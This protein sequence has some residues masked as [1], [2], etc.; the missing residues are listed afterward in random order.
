MSAIKRVEISL[1][2]L[3]PLV[4]RTNAVRS[5][6]S[7]ETP[8]VRVFDDAGVE[9]IGYSWTHGSGGSAIV[10]LLRDR[11]VPRLIGQEAD[12]IEAVWADMFRATQALSIG[13]VT[14][15]AIAAIDIAL[16]DLKG[17]KTGQSLWRMAGGAKDRLPAYTTDAGWLQFELPAVLGNV[18]RDREAGFL[19]S[20][21]K[22]GKPTLGEDLARLRAVR[23]AVGDD[24]E[25]MVDANQCFSFSEGVRRAHAFE[26]CNLGWIEEP[27]PAEDVEGHAKLRAGTSTPIANGESLYH[28]GQFRDY[29][30][31][32][33]CSITQ[34]DIARIGGITPWMKVAHMAEA[35]NIAVCPHYL[36]ELSLSLACGVPNGA[37]LEYIPQ[38]ELITDSR[39]ELKDGSAVVWDRPGTG[40]EWNEQAIAKYAVMDSI[41]VDG[42]K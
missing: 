40:I 16:W 4:Q 24:Y 22:V 39:I 20:K 6:T 21:L 32:G 30:Q 36:M 42:K 11:L 38:L 15:L 19:A 28:P 35:N 34:P 2:N 13:P 25:L 7:Q 27:F 17:K 23:K 10:A 33:A 31:R 37:W 29:F 18:A 41:V 1:A 12:R 26:E 14:S 5:M 8:I 3:P 9:G